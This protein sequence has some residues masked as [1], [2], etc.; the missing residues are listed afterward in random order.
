M[1]MASGAGAGIIE[2]DLSDPKRKQGELSDSM[3]LS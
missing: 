1:V 2:K 3:L